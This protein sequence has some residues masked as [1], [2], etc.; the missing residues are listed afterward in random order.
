MNYSEIVDLALSYADRQDEEVTSRVDKFIKI[1]E[2]R[3]NRKLRTFDMSVRSQLPMVEDQ[4]YYGLPADFGGLRDIEM[5]SASESGRKTLSYVSPEQ[6]NGFSNR[7]G[8]SRKIYYTLV[9]KQIQIW[10]TQTDEFTMEIIYYQKVT[11]LNSTDNENWLAESNPDAYIFGILVEISSFTKDKDTALMWDGRF[12][13]TLGEI[14]DED[15]QDR[16]SGTA[17]EVRLG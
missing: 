3:T 12:R 17:M 15:Q 8:S 1:M 16:W 14:V 5:V 11:N 6:M 10:P 2:S 4:V 13:E 9:A 7:G